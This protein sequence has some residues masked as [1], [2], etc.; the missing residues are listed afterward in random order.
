MRQKPPGIG[1]DQA[2]ILAPHPLPASPAS[3]PQPRGSPTYFAWS[4]MYP[5]GVQLQFHLN[6]GDEVTSS[7]YY[8][9]STHLYSLDLTD[10][11]S[12]QTF[13]VNQACAATCDNS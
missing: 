9:S 12:G 13:S 2:P 11:T 3:R 1:T 4:E 6:P 10:L 7:V 8:D 5:A